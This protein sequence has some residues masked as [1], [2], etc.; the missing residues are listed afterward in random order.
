M[1]QKKIDLF[2]GILSKIKALVD[3]FIVID[4]KLIWFPISRNHIS[5]RIAITFKDEKIVVFDEN[6]EEESVFK[7]IH[8]PKKSK[9]L[10][11]NLQKKKLIVQLIDRKIYKDTNN[12]IELENRPNELKCLKRICKYTTPQYI[13]L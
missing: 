7:V 2:R 13:N 11:D 3:R 6:I 1:S 9:S 4:P 12:S 10:P 8:R 5:K